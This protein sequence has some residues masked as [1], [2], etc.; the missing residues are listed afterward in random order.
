MLKTEIPGATGLPLASNVASEVGDAV[1]ARADTDHDLARI[2]QSLVRPNRQTI[3]LNTVTNLS[4]VLSALTDSGGGRTSR[5]RGECLNTTV[6]QSD[7][8]ATGTLPVQL[9]EVAAVRIG[10][11]TGSSV[12]LN[13]IANQS[14]I[15]RHSQIAQASVGRVADVLFES[16]AHQVDVA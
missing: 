3:E 5:F 10:D 15:G 1:A 2:G 8:G 11:A 9:D 4:I 7:L 12:G 13:M 6:S 14:S 16:T